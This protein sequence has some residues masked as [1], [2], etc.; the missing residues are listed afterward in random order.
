MCPVKEKFSTAYNDVCDFRSSSEPF[1]N[2]MSAHRPLPS[3]NIAVISAAIGESQ[4]EYPGVI[5][6]S[7]NVD[8]ILFT[9][10]EL[11]MAEVA[12]DP[13]N[14]WTVDN[15]LYHLETHILDASGAQTVPPEHPGLIHSFYKA[16]FHLFPC[17]K[18]YDYIIWL[19]PTIVVH[20]EHMA[21]DVIL[22]L[23]DKTG[24]DIVAF[25]YSSSLEDM[26]AENDKEKYARI[27]SD[28]GR[29][30]LPSVAAQLSAY[31]RYNGYSSAHWGN[32]EPSRPLY[33]SW[34][35]DFLAYNMSPRHRAVVSTLLSTWY[36]QLLPLQLLLLEAGR[37]NSDNSDNNQGKN[38]QQQQGRDA[39][40]F[41]F[42]V[43]MALVNPQLNLSLTSLPNS[44][45]NND[46]KG[47]FRINSMFQNKVNRV[48][49]WK[50]N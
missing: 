42:V 45:C 7:I 39:I 48:W 15:T 8:F 10:S 50:F 44:I 6:Q 1:V 18:S 29:R 4:L 36:Q 40:T 43:Q 13:E 2:T 31:E 11:I 35:T 38:K 41:S 3:A 19:E 16:N 5:T 49:K 22:T 21:V 9:N 25:E 28:K 20:S 46:I 17:L 23:I 32:I 12:A 34:C 33:G 14:V 30:E 27:Y 37:E 26:F 24:V 47:S